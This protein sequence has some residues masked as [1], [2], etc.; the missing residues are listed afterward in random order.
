MKKLIVLLAICPMLS[1]S[2][3]ILQECFGNTKQELVETLTKIM[4]GVNFQIYDSGTDY[5]TFTYYRQPDKKVSNKATC[6]FKNGIFYKFEETMTSQHNCPSQ[7]I[8]CLSNTP[9]KE[10]IKA[11]LV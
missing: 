5:I 11:D 1:F 6:Y 10:L 7:G 9:M 8:K 4:I 2:Q 3:T